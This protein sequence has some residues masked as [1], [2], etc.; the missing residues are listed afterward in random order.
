MKRY[1]YSGAP[2]PAPK[3]FVAPHHDPA[4]QFIEVEVA[5]DLPAPPTTVLLPQAGYEDRAKGFSLA[6]APLA[7][8]A[9][10][11]AALVG[12]V[13]WQVPLASLL[14]LL[15]ALGG[16]AFVWLCAYALYVFVSPDGG[17]FLHTVFLWGHLRREQKER[18]RRYGMRGREE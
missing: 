18:F 14:T 6:T 16:F 2:E 3:N 5:R 4:P 1:D 12:I 17:M 15:L 13:G 10:I 9:G 7:T 11:V 8:V